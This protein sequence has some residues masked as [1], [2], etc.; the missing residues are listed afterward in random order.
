M[1]R[2]APQQATPAELGYGTESL[3]VFVDD[4]DAHFARAK[5]AGATIVE[6]PHETIYGEWPSTR[7]RIWRAII[8]FSPVTRET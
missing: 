4:V 8:G 6:E 1:L 2:N 7:P 3:T 5:A